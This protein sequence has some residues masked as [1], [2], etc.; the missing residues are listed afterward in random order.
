MLAALAITIALMF[1]PHAKADRATDMAVKAALKT[2]KIKK[3]VK[4]P[5]KWAKKKLKSLGIP[6]SYVTTTILLAKPAISGKIS[7][8]ELNTG[9]RLGKGKLR[10]DV[11]YNFKDGNTYGYVNYKIEF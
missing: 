2:P 6:E 4:V 8:K 9:W 11:E 10:P 7:T 3:I 5:E 1:C